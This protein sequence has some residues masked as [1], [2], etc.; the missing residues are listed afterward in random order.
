MA[1]ERSCLSQY[2]TLVFWHATIQEFC[3]ND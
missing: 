2:L 3:H 1:S